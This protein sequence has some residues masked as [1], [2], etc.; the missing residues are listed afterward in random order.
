MK[1]TLALFF[2]IL[3][4][5]SVLCTNGYIFV[6]GNLNGIFDSGELG[7]NNCAVSDG[8]S[9]TFTDNKGYYSIQS[10]RDFIFIVKPSGYFCKNWYAENTGIKN[11]CLEPTVESGIFA[12][13]NDIHYADNADDFSQALSDRTL[14]DN[15]DAYLSSF[16]EKINVIN[17]DFIM[18]NGDM[19]AS[20]KDIDDETAMRWMKKVTNAVCTNGKNT[21][22]SVGN[23]EVDKKKEDPYEIFH[24][25]FG[26]EYYSFES[27]G[28][29]YIVL[30]THRIKNGA[31]IYEPDETQLE[32]LAMDIRL[33]GDKKIVVFSH[34]PVFDLAKDENYSKLMTLFSENISWHITAHWHSMIKFFEK[35]FKELTCGGLSGGWWEGSS[36]TGDP[37]GFTLFT[38]SSGEL[39]YA[40]VNLTTDRS[41]LPY[42]RSVLPYDRSVLPYDRSVWFDITKKIPL[43]PLEHIRICVYP[44][45]TGSFSISVNRNESTSSRLIN[46]SG[47]WTEICFYINTSSVSEKFGEI[48][49]TI[50]NQSYRKK[51]YFSSEPV[52]IKLLKDYPQFFEGCTVL[53]KNCLN[54]GQSGTVLTFNDSTDTFMVQIKNLNLPVTVKKGGLYS[55]YGIYRNAETV[56]DPFR[57]FTQEGLIQE[58]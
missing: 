19:G 37:Y 36:P 45:I 12:V 1:K 27:S 11:F 8:V 32:W 41:V 9:F 18:C 47:L 17:P 43:D 57:L 38:V 10:N 20:V 2:C 21:Y 5:I 26:P 58:K 4:S 25:A 34:E 44:K 33:A 30:N 39:D 24:K 13:V 22:F 28:I 55:L 6:D 15:P 52:T 50:E 54:T 56:A 51:L 40:Y 14:I 16:S 31:M 23:H 46:N 48:E 53:L 49:L 35:P 7:L 42:D 29:H 3:L